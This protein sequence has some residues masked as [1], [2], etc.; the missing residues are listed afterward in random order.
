MPERGDTTSLGTFEDTPVTLR[1]TGRKKS[2]SLAVRDGCVTIRAP[3]RVPDA[4]IQELIARK[5]AW[6]RRKLAKHAEAKRLTT[7]AFVD[8]E[9]FLF[10]GER[11]PLQVRDGPKARAELK[12]GVFV[13]HV[14]RAH[15]TE[16][17][18]RSIR[19]AFIRWYKAEAARL[20]E[21]RV[22]QYAER[23]KLS[24]G[25]VSFRDYK[26]MWGKCTSDG[27]LTFN[28]KLVMAPLDIVDYVVVHELAHLLFLNHSAE[29]WS[30]VE[31]AI[32]DYRLHR[33]WL[34]DNGGT[35]AI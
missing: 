28:W 5:A 2:I 34:N 24:P 19:A 35:L 18:A 32:P 4:D 7:R 26:S 3:Q 12:T 21:D 23:M 20:I 17:H 16:R 6:L 31:T 30:V 14:R 29:F 33:K 11:Y 8:G 25:Q 1:R 13:V 27:D 10:L 9:T 15:S 22:R